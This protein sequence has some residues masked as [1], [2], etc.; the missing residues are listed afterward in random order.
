MPNT[1]NKP[2]VSIITVTFN[3]EIYLERTIKSIIAQTS[4]DYEYIIVDGKSKDS[5]LEIADKYKIYISN[6][7]S[8]PDKGLYD[9]MNKGISLANGHFIW[10][11]NAGD[12]IYDK[13]VIEKLKRLFEKSNCDILYGNTMITADDGSE[14]GAKRQKTPKK[15]TYKSLKHGMIVSHQS[16]LCA[17]T[18]CPEYNLKYKYSADNDWMVRCLK[19]AQNIVNANIYISKFLDG[20]RSKQTIIPSLK[21][22][23]HIMRHNYGLLATLWYHI[24][25]AFRFI[26][27]V[28]RNKRF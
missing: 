19:A 23:F 18:I 24:P 25:I 10:F 17:L 21:E 15:L 28:I 12:E 16:F 20:G 26:F 3:A 7:I 5:T 13:H 9:A 1:L 27:F 8:E 4:A 2:F 22:R 11:I 6:C 14:I